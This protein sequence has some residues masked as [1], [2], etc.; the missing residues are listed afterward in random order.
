MSQQRR[1]IH[2][3]NDNDNNNNNNNATVP[4]IETTTLHLAHLQSLDQATHAAA[5]LQRMYKE[6]FPIIQRRNYH[7]KSISELCCCG[8]GLDT[9]HNHS[10]STSTNTDLRRT[11][12]R[13]KQ[14][15]N[16]LGYNQTT[17]YGSRQ[18]QQYHTIHLRLRHAD[19]HHIFYSYEDIAGTMSHELAHCEVSRHNSKFYKLMDEI[20]EQHAV[21]LTRRIVVDTMGFPFHSPQAY[22]LGGGTT[23]TSNGTGSHLSSLVRKQQTQ[24]MPQGPQ[25]LGGESKLIVQAFLTP[26]EAAGIA[27]EER[28][29]RQAD[30]VWCMPC[31]TE[32]E[33]IE[34][35]CHE[36]STNSHDTTILLNQQ[37]K[38]SAAVAVNHNDKTTI[39]LANDDDEDDDTYDENVQRS[40]QQECLLCTYMNPPST[41]LVCGMC[42]TELQSSIKLIQQLVRQDAIEACKESE[43]ERSK[44]EFGFN[45]YGK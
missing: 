37:F 16:I 33:I 9:D 35:W 23:T 24:W 41:A 30:E 38:V 8:D 40:K 42:G 5:L 12:K 4:N 39:D 34:V 27:A 29:R 45:I 32:P 31:R 10:T 17:T 26:G 19:N 43:V 25:T 14:P 13:R 7:V 11:K 15:N 3:L 21:L 22:T 44:A 2:T 1:R 6:F 36:S 18:Q 28:R 20:Q